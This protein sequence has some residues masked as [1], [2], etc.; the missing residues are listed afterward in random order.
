MKKINLRMIVIVVS[1]LSLI[2][3]L[4]DEGVEGAFAKGIEDMIEKEDGLINETLAKEMMYNKVPNSKIVE[5]TYDEERFIPVF[6]GRLIKHEKEYRISLDAKTGVVLDYKEEKLNRYTEVYEGK[7]I[8]AQEAHKIMLDRATG[9]EIKGFKFEGD[10]EIPTYEGIVHK[11]G[12]EI[13]ILLD[14]RDGKII[15]IDRDDV[16]RVV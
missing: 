15:G 2:F 6:Q 13:A 10:A 3:I 1:M 5:F 11:D 7:V 8:T 4:K 12:N 9:G 16:K 14:A